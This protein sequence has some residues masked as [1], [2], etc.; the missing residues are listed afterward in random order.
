[1]STRPRVHCGYQTARVTNFSRPHSEQIR[2]SLLNSFAALSAAVGWRAWRRSFKPSTSTPKSLI[3]HKTSTTSTQKWTSDVALLRSFA[4]GVRLFGR[5][6]TSLPLRRRRSFREIDTTG[7]L[8]L[9]GRSRTRY[10]PFPDDLAAAA[11]GYRDVG[12]RVGNT[13]GRDAWLPSSCHTCPCA[14]L[15]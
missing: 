1:M 6:R 2:L 4:F 11:D 14:P 12:C 7:C 10:L 8:S 5:V 3:S 13:P 15:R 9:P